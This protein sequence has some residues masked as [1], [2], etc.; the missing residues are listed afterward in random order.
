MQA[1]E[2]CRKNKLTYAIALGLMLASLVW[3]IKMCLFLRIHGKL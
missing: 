3:F 1:V 2:D